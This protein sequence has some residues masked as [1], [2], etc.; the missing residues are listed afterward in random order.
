MS[1]SSFASAF[2]GTFGVLLALLLA[3]SCLL[4]VPILMCS[5]LIVLPSIGAAVDAGKKVREQREQEEREKAAATPTEEVQQSPRGELPKPES[6]E[7]NEP[8]MP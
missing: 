6:V 8:V 2:G 5:G 7:A 4:G 1:E 3:F